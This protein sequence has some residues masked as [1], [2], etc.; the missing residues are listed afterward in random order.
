[1]IEA[2]NS[3][4]ASKVIALAGFAGAGKDSFAEL[5]QAAFATRHQQATIVSSG[6]LIRDYVTEH[7]LGDPGDRALLR[8]VVVDVAAEHG[9]TFWLERALT[10]AAQADVILYP[11]LRQTVEVDF[12]HQHGGIVIGID[13][14]IKVRYART[15]AR[16][17]PGDDIDFATFTA[18]EQAERRGQGQQIEV[19]MGKVDALVQNDGSFEQ[20]GAVATAIAEAY[21][22]KLA[23]SY[24]GSHY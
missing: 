12:L 22:D 3:T 10:T 5:L 19:V 18:N 16:Q 11:G 15:Q 13:V 9:Y 14:P 8:Q 23:K 2:M 7:Q 17:R 4:I 20:L 1:M 21:P 24:Q 6:D